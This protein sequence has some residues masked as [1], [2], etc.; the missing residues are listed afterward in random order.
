MRKNFS[1]FWPPSV[2]YCFSNER[3]K[4]KRER[5]FNPLLSLTLLRTAACEN[6][7]KNILLIIPHDSYLSFST[8]AIHFSKNDGGGEVN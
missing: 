8:N 1:F 6:K 4:E 3:K 2:F 5:G 7:T